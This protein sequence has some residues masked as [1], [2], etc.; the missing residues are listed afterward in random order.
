MAEIIHAFGGGADEDCQSQEALGLLENILA[1]VRSGEIVNV[2]IVLIRGDGAIN[3]AWSG[4]SSRW[5][6]MA[7]CDFL[8]RDLMDL[9]EDG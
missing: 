1:R 4:G 3:T 9:I 6:L 7:G 2:A 5:R 8:K